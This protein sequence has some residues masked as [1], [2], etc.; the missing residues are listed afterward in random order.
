MGEGKGGGG[1][2]NPDHPHPNLPPSQGGRR[3]RVFDPI[4]KRT[5]PEGERFPP[6]PMGTLEK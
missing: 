4:A 6:S 3:L 2:K 1:L 5:S